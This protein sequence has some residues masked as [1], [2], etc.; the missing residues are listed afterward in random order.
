MKQYHKINFDCAVCRLYGNKYASKPV[1]VRE[2]SV[3]KFLD[4]NKPCVEFTRITC[5]TKF[6]LNILV[7][8]GNIS[9]SM[10]QC[11]RIIRS[12]YRLSTKPKIF[13]RIS[14]TRQYSFVYRK[15]RFSKTSRSISAYWSK[16]N[17]SLNIPKITIRMENSSSRRRNNV[18]LS[19]TMNGHFPLESGQVLPIRE[20]LLPP[21]SKAFSMPSYR[22]EE[23]NRNVSFWLHRPHAP[24]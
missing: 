23:M 1:F 20:R 18:K 14:H 22:E 24:M 4:R 15:F 19:L 10:S 7:I 16:R 11:S 6:Q 5:I 8:I 3:I 2:L 12:T 17:I 9:R 21:L 13:R